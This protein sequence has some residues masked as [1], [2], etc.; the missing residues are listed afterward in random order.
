MPH[1]SDNLKQRAVSGAIWYG[2]SRFAVQGI[3]W[4]ITILVARILT[5][6]D[7]GLMGFAFL[8][9]GMADL[10]SE[11]GIG[12]AI[13]QRQDLDNEDLSALFWFSLA[14]SLFIY[15]IGWLAAPLIAIF[16]KQQALALIL[17]VLM[18][19]FLISSLRIISANLL[20]K[21]IEFKH[22]SIIETVANIIAALS[23]LGMTYTGFGVW[24]LI[25]GILIR[26][27]MQTVGCQFLQPWWPKRR[28]TWTRLRKVMGFGL[29]VSAGRVAWYAYSNAD[30]L[31]V[32]KLLGQQALGMYTMVFQLATM[33]LDRIMSVI[34]QVAF[35]IYSELQSQPER[36]KRYF[37]KIATLVSLI[38]FPILAGAFLILDVAVPL[39]LTTKWAPI[40][41]PLKIMCPVAILMSIS[42]IS[43]P[44]VLA[45]GRPDLTLK[46]NLVCLAM[47]PI[48]FAVGTRFD[49]V[50]VCWAWLILY[51]WIT[52]FYYIKV[53]QVLG[54][55]WIEFLQALAPATLSTVIMLVCG[56][57]ARWTISGIFVNYVELLALIGLGIL[58]YFTILIWRYRAELIEFKLLLGNRIR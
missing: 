12:A 39:L 1:M 26:Q 45:A 11:L 3:T 32:G 35:P 19:S 48:G 56:F 37:L 15:L 50:G 55:G 24:S 40:V 8:V 34:N 7:Y 54:F 27:A 2:G 23:T 20:T 29:N 30:F 22:R 9:T 5:P 49:I 10:I 43:S 33:P 31:V 57:L 13:I 46:Y 36:L 51:P 58:S 18:L 53:K 21:R 17:R 28:F 6:S 42:H 47:L 16:F 25:W 44:A 38:I 41:I 14:L 52:L 4:A